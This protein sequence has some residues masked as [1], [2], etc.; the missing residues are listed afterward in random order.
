MPVYADN[1]SNRKLNRV[2]L[3]KGSV[4]APLSPRRQKGGAR[5]GKKK[6]PQGPELPPGGLPEPE[7]VKVPKLQLSDK[8]GEADRKVGGGKGWKQERDEFFSE[9]APGSKDIGAYGGK[10]FG[11]R[12]AY[13]VT[14]MYAAARGHNTGPYS[15]KAAHPTLQLE[16]SKITGILPPMST[17]KKKETSLKSQLAKRKKRVAQG[18]VFEEHQDAEEGHEANIQEKL[19]AIKQ[20]IVMLKK[21]E[22]ANIDLSNAAAGQSRGPPVALVQKYP[23]KVK[24]SVRPAIN[25]VDIS[26]RAIGKYPGKYDY[27]YT[28]GGG[29]RVSVAPP[30]YHF[31]DMG[32]YVRP[33]LMK[34][35][36]HEL[37][38]KGPAQ[39]KMSVKPA[40]NKVKV[41]NKK[42]KI[43]NN[44]EVKRLR[45][46]IKISE[47][48]IDKWKVSA[49]I[50]EIDPGTAGS[51]EYKDAMKKVK[52]YTGILKGEKAELAEVLNFLST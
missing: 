25:K 3:E 5:E 6:K 51:K 16:K 12:Y 39:I 29:R 27:G 15:F 18:F 1:P 37:K 24:V 30:G 17:L 34:D 2:G 21:K 36:V 38:L 11:G 42:N 9:N 49:E 19:D 33:Q 23:S 52:K 4:K 31:M 47:K 50:M 28:E 10:L 40:I 45:K 20:M 8:T 26:E 7:K 32:K 41:L 13:G 22:S 44:P 48:K 46:E 43:E 35:E 14:G